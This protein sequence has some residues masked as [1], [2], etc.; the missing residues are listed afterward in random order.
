MVAKRGPKAR[1][2]APDVS[3]IDE[4]YK[5][6]RQEVVKVAME[7]LG[8]EAEGMAPCFKS[9]KE[10]EDSD[11]LRR[12]GYVPMLKPSKGDGAEREQYSHGNDPLWMRPKEISDKYKE[13]PAI[14]ANEALNAARTGAEGEY[15][16]LRQE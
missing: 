2:K 13:A 16:D 6:D 5:D 8:A 12:Q 7:A 10:S 3:I 14:L 11:S 15:Q 9:K 1:K 4:V